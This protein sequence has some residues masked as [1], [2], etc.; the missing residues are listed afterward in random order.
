MADLRNDST[1]D[2]QQVPAQAALN[3]V[4]E[5]A[6]QLARDAQTAANAP[7]ASQQVQDGARALEQAL[8]AFG[9]IRAD[10]VADQKDQDLLNEL[11]AGLQEDKN[12][13]TRLWSARE[14]LEDTQRG[15]EDSLSRPP[16][17]DAS[18]EEIDERVLARERFEALQPA[19]ELARAAEEWLGQTGEA[20]RNAASNLVKFYLGQ[21]EMADQYPG[22]KETVQVN[23]KDTVQPIV[24][25]EVEAMGRPRMEQRMED[26][27][28]AVEQF[29]TASVP[30]LTAEQR[31]FIDEARFAMVLNDASRLWEARQ[32]LDRAAEHNE[33][34]AR[35][36]EVARAGA[37]LIGEALGTS[38]SF[39]PRQEVQDMNPERRKSMNRVMGVGATDVAGGDPGQRFEWMHMLGR[40]FGGADTS[41]DA[42]AGDQQVHQDFSQLEN[43]LND[44]RKEGA[45]VEV[46]ITAAHQAVF[47]KDK[48]KER[49]GYE[50]RF[51]A[52]VD[53]EKVFDGQRSLQAGG[54]DPDLKPVFQE[55]RNLRDDLKSGRSPDEAVRRLGELLS[56]A[57]GSPSEDRD[58]MLRIQV[59]SGYYGD[60][61]R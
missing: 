6:Q 37:N 18:N 23:A 20:F 52:W 26:L 45:K 5:G 28:Q 55:L 10:Q 43:R 53:G 13:P 56:A 50:M 41:R 33:T 42:V 22:G 60:T 3:A 8:D 30:D 29:D 2:P 15:L 1:P 61:K 57:Q 54:R 7:G 9:H 31:K 34:M 46:Q 40:L 19:T 25:P 59:D 11:A 47:H 38:V 17:A 51:E 48:V 49:V 58:Q 35:A 24:P 16:A 39:V 32:S 21:F 4:Q 27:E 14:R 12:D 36:A 44:I